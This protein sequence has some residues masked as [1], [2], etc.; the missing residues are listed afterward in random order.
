MDWFSWLSKTT[1][2]PTL[3]YEYGL[4]FVQNQLEEDDIAYFNHEF[5][6]SMGISVAKH[7]LEILKLAK[8]QTTTKA[9]PA[10]R[11]LLAIK[12]TKRRVSKYI[13]RNWNWIGCEEAGGL[14]L[15][16][17]R[18]TQSRSIKWRSSSG[19]LRRN[20]VKTEAK[21][22]QGTLLLTNGGGTMLWSCSSRFDGLSTSMVVEDDDDEKMEGDGDKYWSSTSH[23]VEDQIRWDAMFQDLKPT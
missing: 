15:V 14:A 20:S 9:P 16:P 3:V 1:L 21:Q 23:V 10:T 17:F 7:R 19:M 8:K 18:T 11:F 12:R 2:D 13:R 6:Q 5:L 22:K 4:T